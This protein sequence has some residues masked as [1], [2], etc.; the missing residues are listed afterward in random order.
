M[1]RKTQCLWLTILI[2]SLL[3]A[4][5]SQSSGF[6]E[7]KNTKRYEVPS[8]EKP[9]AFNAQKELELLQSPEWK[10]FI[11]K[12]GSWTVAKWNQWRGT[13][14]TAY[15]VG[16]QISGYSFID[17]YNAENAAR[18]F[19][20]ENSS[21][22]KL[23]LT[24]LELIRAQLILRKWCVS[25]RQ[26]VGDIPIF[27]SEIELR[28]T[29][30]ARV[31]LFRSNYHP[32]IDVNTSPT[33]SEAHA[34]ESAKTGL[35][36]NPQTDQVLGAELLIYPIEN[37]NHIDYHLAYRVELKTQIPLGYWI[38][39]VDAHTGEILLRY[40]NIKFVAV[41]GTVTGDYYPM[42]FTDPIQQ[43]PFI[44]E[45]VDVSGV[46]AD[47]TD[48]NGY[49][50]VTVS[51]PGSYVVHSALS[52][53]YLDVNYEDGPDAS[54]SGTATANEPHDWNWNTSMGL[55]DEMNVYYHAQF[56][57]TYVTTLDIGF[58]ALDYP[59]PA[60]VRVGSNYDNAYW[61]GYGI[62]F[63]EGSGQPGGFYNLAL[64]C[65][66]IYHEYTHG[67]TDHIV[68]WPYYGQ[69]GA[70]DEGYSDY[71]A[72]TLTDEPL[73]GEVLC[74]SEDYLRTVDNTYRY[75]DD[76]I[77]EVH[78]DG[79]IVSGVLWDMRKALGSGLADTLAHFARY[80]DPM[81]FEELYQ[82]VLVVDDDD[83]DLSN[84]TP[85]FDAITIAFGN[86]GIGPGLS[87]FTEFLEL[88]GDLSWGVAWGDYDNDGDLDLA[89]SQGGGGQ[90]KLYVNNYPI[91][92][93]TQL[94]QFGYRQTPTMVWGDYDNDGD[95]DIAQS[96]WNEDNRLYENRLS[97]DG[98]PTFISHHEFGTGMLSMGMAWADYDNDGDLDLAVVRF[99]EQNHLYENRL[100]PDGS[101]SFVEYNEFGVWKCKGLVWGDFDNDGDPDLAVA[102]SGINKLYINNYPDSPLFTERTDVF[103]GGGSG[104]NLVITPGDFDNDSDLD[105]FVSKGGSLPGGRLYV[106]NFPDLTFTEFPGFGSDFVGGLGVA[107]GDFDNDGDKD[108]GV[109]NHDGVPN[110]LCVNNY[111]IESFSVVD[112]FSQ[113]AFEGIAWGDY[114]NDGDLD[115]ALADGT[116]LSP[117]RLYIN[118]AN[119]YAYIKVKLIGR[120]RG[121]SIT[122]YTNRMGVG[123]K[124]KVYDPSTV[125]LLGYH[126][127]IAGSG[128]CSMNAVEAHFGVPAGNTYDV[129][130]YWPTSG[131]TIDTLVTAPA[132]ITVWEYC[133]G[134]A[135]GD[136]VINSAD[137]VF[138]SCYLFK[139]GP[140]PDPWMAGD[141][142]AD[143]YINSSDI[144]YLNNYLYKRGPA[145]PPPNCP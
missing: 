91:S 127:I 13:P 60:T 21:L 141:A 92:S 104:I 137:I 144:V 88:G 123:A 80:G 65:D 119:N 25:F 72:C 96:N 111:P 100:Y 118:N 95:L 3:Q 87:H 99:E 22:L 135:N 113:G 75:P 86:H 93:F 18:L 33:L 66:V 37:V 46:G 39:Y 61:D 15:G 142:N 51:E 38:C 43:A 55:M 59:M 121:L 89:V 139:G 20:Q 57:H 82:E 68:N 129:E 40:N 34:V 97:P 27:N 4:L 12:N 14:H 117:D 109:T 17:D 76:Y 81:S 42:Y 90:N 1:H 19:L 58:H 85:H 133:R 126:E 131:I 53:P 23:N 83:G 125:A 31:F 2:L 98:T 84:G 52:G 67:I 45:R 62:N 7:S 101:P 8:S 94:N 10:D 128:F 24:D 115:V 132:V 6:S 47:T 5:P 70:M 41:Y 107:W 64:F 105:V 50:N 78:W 56:I 28:I 79:Q 114:D 108:L 138:L 134:D 69:T 26:K 140:P 32:Q 106:N 102:G 73:I 112:E 77:G 103:G 36:F 54:Y 30:D 130:V 49:Y 71:F 143:C 124:V 44:Y 48:A 145:P 122:E 116:H 110:K 29:S 35:P 11:R 74:V 120:N 136:K 63:G 16:I 9:I